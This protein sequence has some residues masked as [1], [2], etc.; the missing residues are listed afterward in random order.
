MCKRNVIL[1]LLL[2]CL[3][4]LLCAQKVITQV[5]PSDT[6]SD[7]AG[8][9]RLIWVASQQS[10]LVVWR[11]GGTI[12]GRFIRF[13]GGM[14]PV[15]N[16]QTNMGSTDNSFDIAQGNNGKYVLIYETQQ[17]LF[18]QLLN[19]QLLGEGGSNSIESGVTGTF[20]RIASNPNG[21]FQVV[22]LGSSGAM[23]AKVVKGVSLDSTG[24]SFEASRIL[25]NAGVGVTFQSLS[26]ARNPISGN[27]MVMFLSGDSNTGKL[28]GMNLN[29]F[30]SVINRPSFQ[31]VTAGL[32]SWGNPAF[33][34]SGNGIAVWAEKGQIKNK[35]IVNNNVSGLTSTPSIE[36][37][38]NSLQSSSIYHEISKQYVGLWAVGNKIQGI[39]IIPTNGKFGQTFTV[40][41]LPAPMNFGRN[42]VASYDSTRG[43]IFA[44]WEDSNRP[45]TDGGSGVNFKIH[46]AIFEMSEG[47]TR[48]G[49]PDIA[50]D[51]PRLQIIPDSS[52]DSAK[53]M[54]LLN[55]G[56]GVLKIES[57]SLENEDDGQDCFSLQ[58]TRDDCSKGQLGPDKRCI[59][60]INCNDNGCNVAG[61]ETKLN[62]FSNDPDENPFK[63]SVACGAQ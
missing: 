2:V 28:N 34:P 33:S 44:V 53:S 37:D 62:V 57:V 46:G 49:E 40:A 3:P 26:I 58:I 56:G 54:H 51:V 32:H 39:P 55:E 14:D 1:L 59:I 6:F 61:F 45:A 15:K 11:Q 47:G 24:R 27:Y 25:S 4:G 20:P 17:G 38:A 29:P 31:S 60:I 43:R 19:S 21:Q 52:N 63:I 7:V 23:N 41:T 22:Y 18:S 36:S 48:E 8:T 9:P 10:W 5:A 35:R 30:G 50:A 16:L 42:V 12:A 13:D